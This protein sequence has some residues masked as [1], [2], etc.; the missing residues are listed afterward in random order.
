MASSKASRS[1]QPDDAL[2]LLKWH[3]QFWMK[4]QYWVPYSHWALELWQSKEI[5]DTDCLWRAHGDLMP[6]SRN[7]SQIDLFLS[8]YLN[9]NIFYTISYCS[10]VNISHSTLLGIERRL[11]ICN[12]DISPQMPAPAY[13]HLRPHLPERTSIWTGES[14][15][16]IDVDCG[17]G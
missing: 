5:V 15:S 9:I 8:L 1:T 2:P 7:R 11:P 10:A 16:F 13:A 17:L 14:R 4:A 12:C 6:P 3:W